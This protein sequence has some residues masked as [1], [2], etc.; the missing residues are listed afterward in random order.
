[1][2][3]S[4]N[5]SNDPSKKYQC[6]YCPVSMKKRSNIQ[7]H[8]RIHTG[9]KPFAC[10][11]CPYRAAQ[12]ANLDKHVRYKHPQQ[13]HQLENA[14]DQIRYPQSY[15]QSS[16][17]DNHEHFRNL[18]KSDQLMTEP[19]NCSDVDLSEK[20]WEGRNDFSN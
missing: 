11:L 4:D 10:Q 6:P 17:I 5:G 1:M 20:D 18:D 16:R 12:K 13:F 8:I 15:Q 3:T 14:H 7:N 2:S 9:E 19:N